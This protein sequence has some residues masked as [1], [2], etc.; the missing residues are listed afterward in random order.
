MLAGLLALL[1]V[2]YGWHQPFAAAAAACVDLCIAATDLITAC[3]KHL[4]Q[5]L[6]QLL[7][8]LAPLLWFACLTLVTLITLLIHHRPTC[9]AAKRPSHCVKAKISVEPYTRP[10]P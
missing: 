9:I 6:V 4:H 3:S 5:L 1:S 2:C 10:C 8:L 7:L